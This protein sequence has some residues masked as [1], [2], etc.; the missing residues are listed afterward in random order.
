MDEE[1]MMNA[2][3]EEVDDDFDFFSEESEEGGDESVTEP[4]ADD[5]ETSPE[6]VP[7]E[8]ETE[9]ENP[10]AE[11]EPKYK[12]K[13]NGQEMEVPASELVAYA[14]KGMNYDH[15]R[16]E[17][18]KATP[19]YS[20][21]SSVAER[22]GM[23]VAQYIEAYNKQQQEQQVQKNI[24]AGMPEEAAREMQRIRAENETLKRKES[25]WTAEEQRNKEVRAFMSAYPDV[26]EI[27]QEVFDA[28]FNTGEP[29]VSAYQRYENQQLKKQI[30]TMKQNQAN[31]ARA[32]GSV[33]SN[34][35]DN[36]DD[37][38][39]GFLY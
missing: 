13:F 22:S 14:Q 34:A 6:E 26:K 25:E 28:H 19:A 32:V 5:A 39:A 12:V 33:Q 8:G 1:M 38:L 17:L 36:A 18:D 4:T 11:D 20:L 23:T 37:F 31:K 24:K 10:A 7:D 3:A 30:E 9:E 35:S 2:G 16:E 29:L 27:P 15:I 21:L